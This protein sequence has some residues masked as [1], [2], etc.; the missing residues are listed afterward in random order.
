MSL[1]KEWYLPA[2]ERP[3]VSGRAGMETMFMGI[4]DR[5]KG[6]VTEGT[7]RLPRIDGHGLSPKKG[8][9]NDKEETDRGNAPAI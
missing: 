6:R 1:A 4:Q 7:V 5:F 9:N 3:S 8:L 2:G